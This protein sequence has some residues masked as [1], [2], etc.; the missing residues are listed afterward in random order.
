LME[1][2]PDMSQVKELLEEFETNPVLIF[3]AGFL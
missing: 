2:S 3:M 1:V